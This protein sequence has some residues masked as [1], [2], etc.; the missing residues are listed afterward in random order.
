MKPKVQPRPLP[1]KTKKKQRG[2]AIPTM[3]DIAARAN[4]SIGTVSRVLN[5]A[6]DVDKALRMRVEEAVR[7]LGYRLNSRTRSVVHTR[8]RIIG[9]IQC[10]D[11]GLSRG[12]AL[13][14]QGV[15]E[16]CTAAGYCLLFA[17][18][19]FP[20]DTSPDLL[21]MPG[22]IE[23]P[24]LADCIIVAGSLTVNTL[25]ALDRHD[26]HYVLLANHLVDEGEPAIASSYVRYDDESGCYEATRYLAQLGHVHI[27]YLG[28]AS[29]SWHRSRYKGYCRAMA[30]LGLETHVHTIALADDEY[31]N[32]RAAISYILEQQWP[33]TAILAASDELAYGAREGLRQ[34]RRDVPKDVSLIS[35]EQQVGHSHGSNLT[36]VCVDMAEVG[37]QLA[38]LAIAQIESQ[39]PSRHK[40]LVPTVFIKRS[41][42]RPLR[43]EEQMLL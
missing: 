27:W 29:R 15:E 32:G 4:V 33:V 9:L 28:D 19:L 5:R 7:T 12:Q 38:R 34:H 3:K 21:P 36:S 14:L 16:Y 24:G 6:Q 13:L 43:Q 25:A 40:A 39:Q 30:E 37:R 18:H 8:S 26:F 10:N 17:R 41:S 2:S 35:F 20:E 31:E 23:I 22:A 42:C 11:S 1:G